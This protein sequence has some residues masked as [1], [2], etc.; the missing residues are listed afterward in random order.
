MISKRPNI[1]AIM[2]D[3]Q[4]FD[5]VAALGNPIIQTPALDRLVREGTSFTSAY[6]TS[7][8]CVASR[9][10]F[11]LGEYPHRTGSTSNT[12]MPQDR[13]SLMMYL[14]GD[15]YQ[16]HGIGKMHFSPDSRKLW[17]YESRVFSEEG[18]GEDDFRLFLDQNGYDHIVAP[19]GER[20]E[21]YYVPQPSQL[22]D[23]LH[24]TTWMGDKTIEFLN[25]R[26]EDRPFFCW[27]SF[28]KPHPPF[29]AP[30]PWSRLYRLIEMM[31]PHL[32]PDSETFLSYWNHF[33]NRYKYRDQ[34][35]DMNLLRLMRAAYYATISQI[36]YQ[37]G[38][39]LNRL[40][41]QGILDQTLILFTSDHGEM[42]GDFNCYGKRSFL[43]SAAR[44]PLLV[45]YPERFS[46]GVECEQPVSL[47]D[48]LPT[49]LTAAGQSTESQHAG[50]DLAE[51]AN[52]SL[53][54][55]A[56][57]GQFSHG[58]RGLYALISQDLKY[59]YSVADRKEWLFR[60]LAG[61]LEDRNLAGNPAFQRQLVSH[62]E[63]LINRF[64][65]DGYEE[66]IDEQSWRQFPLPEPIPEDPDAWQLFQDGRSV[67]DR[68]PDGYSPSVDPLRRSEQPK[69]LCGF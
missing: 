35:C 68:F 3:Q 50:F 9:C 67:S 63:F 39:I 55:E 47:V 24:H 18:G 23:R 15:G 61:R 19:Q 59:I 57:I 51:I 42:L 28:I 31:P 66:P 37:I 34:G 20:S 17:G 27:T 30:V 13:T 4:R 41:A 64:Q 38:R 6:C 16:T 11:L 29:E 8:V 33:Q 53:E 5:T 26:E 22:P 40:E 52:G 32:P 21:Y 2:T 45:R 25:N 10:S 46:A 48:V 44:V 43:D 58:D 54:R 56:V 60:R 69:G 65:A 36:D 62:R 1:L 49:C 7:P 14:N 12:P